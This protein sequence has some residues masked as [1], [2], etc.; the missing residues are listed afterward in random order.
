MKVLR[1]VSE[2]TAVL[3][4]AIACFGQ[5]ATEQKKVLV[6]RVDTTA[7]I[8]VEANSFRSLS[9]KQ[10][11]LGYWLY[12]ASIAIDPIFYDQLSHYGLRQKRVLE[13]IAAHPQGADPKAMEKILAFTKLF[14]ANRG[15]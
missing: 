4:I 8:Q 13:G 6:D 10:Q 5:E 15:N 2:I 3:L 1:T 12:E 11:Q 9:P 7:F 14:W